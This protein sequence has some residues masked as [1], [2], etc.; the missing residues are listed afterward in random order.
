[1]TDKPLHSLYVLFEEEPYISLL[2]RKLQEFDV[3][4]VQNYLLKQIN[5]SLD[6]VKDQLKAIL[7]ELYEIYKEDIEKDVLTEN[8]KLQLLSKDFEELVKELKEIKVSEEDKSKLSIKNREKLNNLMLQFMELYKEYVE[9]SEAK[10][11][12][13]TQIKHVHEYKET[14]E[15]LLDLL[16][17]YPKHLR[18][19]FLDD[20]ELKALRYITDIYFTFFAHGLVLGDV[21]AFK[22]AN[23]IILPLI[24]NIQETSL[25]KNAFFLSLL[26]RAP[27]IEPYVEQIS[28]S[29]LKGESLKDLY[30]LDVKEKLKQ[31]KHEG[32]NR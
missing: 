2:K 10:R 16:E 29:E 3:D 21:E 8:E 31:I 30:G 13:E 25:S 26:H 32:D 7:V 6:E 9:L 28:K 15:K 11:I 18:F 5:N 14:F 23:F 12:L 27:L 22:T 1:M 17:S 20:V 19:G 4:K 24:I